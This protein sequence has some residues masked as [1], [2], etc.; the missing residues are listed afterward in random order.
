MSRASPEHHLQL[1]GREGGGIKD[2]T[3]VADGDLPDGEVLLG[4]Q[5]KGRVD[6]AG[7]VG[8]LDNAEGR[9]FG[10]PAERAL[11][12]TALGVEDQDEFQ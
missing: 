2:G 1:I 6:L 4:H 12:T 9:R 5:V 3:L 11:I 8:R 10:K 7:D